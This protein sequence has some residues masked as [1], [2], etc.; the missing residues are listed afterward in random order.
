M[1]IRLFAFLAILL[2]SSSFTSLSAQ[3]SGRA[4]LAGSVGA[5]F[6]DMSASGFNTIG[7]F[8]NTGHEYETNETWGLALGYEKCLTRELQLRLELE[9]RSF[10]DS[11]FSL[12]ASQPVAD[13]RGAMTD[14]WTVMT[15]L[16]IDKSVSENF[17]IYA[18]GGIGVSIFEMNA[19]DGI[20]TARRNDADFSYMLGTGVTCKLLSNVEL[21]FGYRYTD[22]GKA[23]SSLS[24]VG[25]QGPAGSLDIDMDSSQLMLT[26]RVFRR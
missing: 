21:D 22:L 16:W 20:V 25:G 3:D 24:L 15:N 8:T 12:P 14:R 23:N 7:N 17:E 11:Y 1:Y 2:T 26:L 9:G 5:D 10:G 13:Y 4:Y 18:G 6:L 19:T